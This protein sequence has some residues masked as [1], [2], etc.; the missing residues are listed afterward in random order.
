MPN[1]HRSE[2][3]RRTETVVRPVTIDDVEAIIRIYN[4]YIL[5]TIITFEEQAISATEMARRIS[6]VA[7]AQLPWLVAEQHGNIL[8]YAYAG[9][10]NSRYGY[11]FSVESTV[12]LDP[13]AVGQGLG[14]KLYGSLLSILRDMKLHVVIGG[15]AL[16]NP[17]SVAL[18]EKLGFRKVA[19]YREVG[20]KFQQWIDV[21]YWQASL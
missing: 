19:H 16:P 20:F 8:G 10:W 3:T 9:R 15:I 18:H 21:G 11:R 17:S 7:A 5:N 12:Y 2:T 14:R 1:D 4:H 13:A 6:G